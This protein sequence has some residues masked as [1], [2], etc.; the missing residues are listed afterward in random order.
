M[1]IGAMDMQ[2]VREQLK[3]YKQ[4]QRGGRKKTILFSVGF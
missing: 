4:E 2:K 1:A 3:H